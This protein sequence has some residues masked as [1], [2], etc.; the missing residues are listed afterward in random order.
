VT[1][2]QIRGKHQ[3][4]HLFAG[5]VESSITNQILTRDATNITEEQMAEYRSSFN[6]FDKDK[7]GQLDQLEFRGCLLS[8]G[9]DIPAVASGDDFEF[10]R[11]WKLVDPN[12]D[13]SATFGEFVNFMAEERADAATKDDLLQQFELLSGGQ[14]YILPNQMNDLEPDLVAYC[15]E[16]MAPYEGGP[17]GALDYA[18]FAAAAFGEET[19]I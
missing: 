10:Q 3:G 14:P 5:T 4:V 6:H 8:L 19:A 1:I 13:N 9:V 18:S 16:N 11:I 17:E 15:I 12:G 7:S 2:E